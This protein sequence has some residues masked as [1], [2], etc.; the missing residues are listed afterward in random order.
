MKQFT[1]TDAQLA[2][3][4][5]AKIPLWGDNAARI[6]SVESEHDSI[7]V[8]CWTITRMDSTRTEH[9]LLGDRVIPCDEYVVT[10]EVI[11]PSNSRW[12]P[13]DGDVVEVARESNFYNALKAC[14]LAELGWSIDQMEFFEGGN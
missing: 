3:A 1:E 5:A 12:E 13:D 7:T 8:G 2:S 14:A 4:F 11:T 10:A 9:S 6:E